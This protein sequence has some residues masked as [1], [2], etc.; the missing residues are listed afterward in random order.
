MMGSAAVRLIGRLV[1]LARPSHANIERGNARLRDDGPKRGPCRAQLYRRCT[2]RRV[3][4]LA[5]KPEVIQTV[6]E[7]ISNEKAGWQTHGAGIAAPN[8]EFGK[9]VCRYQS[10]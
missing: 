3:R 1:S 5:A 4:R 8:S 2:S 10:D 6:T 7:R 9:R